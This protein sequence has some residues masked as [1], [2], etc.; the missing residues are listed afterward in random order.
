MVVIKYRDSPSWDIQITFVTTA[1]SQGLI[2][3]FTNVFVVR[4][5]REKLKISSVKLLHLVPST[6]SGPFFV[7][8][9]TH[10]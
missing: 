9:T 7:L 4:R 3:T 1:I 6:P 10:Y 5:M 2:P 8:T